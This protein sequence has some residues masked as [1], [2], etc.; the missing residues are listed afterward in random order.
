MSASTAGALALALASTTLTNLAYLREH[1]AAAALPCLSIRRP[2]R[3]ARLLLSDRRWLLGFAMESGG[4]ALYAAALA[5][6]SL[7]L[8]QSIAAGGV[9]VLAVVS[10]RM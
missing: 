2:L 5:L 3:S 4:F 10:S 1:D 7:S 9:G 6:A 8:V